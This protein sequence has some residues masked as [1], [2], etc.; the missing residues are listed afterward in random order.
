MVLS[1]R[2]FFTLTGASAATIILGSSLKNFYADASTNQ[3]QLTKKF[4]E[5]KPD[6]QGILDLPPGFQY[7]ILSPLGAI[8]DDGVAVPN[9]HDG[10]ATFPGTGNTT[11][12][13]RNHETI[14][15][16]PNPVIAPQD[17]KYD[18]LSGG[19]TTTLI[20]NRS[21]Q[22]VKHF[23][24]LAGTNRNCGGGTTPW[25]SWL[26]SEEDTSTLS[27]KHGYNFEVPAGE[28]VTNPV[29]LVAM[30]RFRHEAIAFEPVSGYIYQTEDQL[31]SC[32][33]RFIPSEYGNL[34]AGG[35]LETLKI[36]GMPKIDTSSNFPLREPKQVEWIT[37][38]QVDPDSDTLRYEAQ[39]KGAA[40]FRRGEGICL[41]D[42]QI[43]WTCTN[44]GKAQA[45]QIF[46]YDIKA[47]TIELFLESESKQILDYPD[48]I[49][50]SPFGDL[51]ACEDGAG[52]QYLVG[53]TPQGKCY[54][55]AHNA[56]NNSE[57]AGVC[58]SPDTQT[59]FVNIYNPGMTLAIWGPWQ[60]S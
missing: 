46:R 34:Q 17:H 3:T 2:N 24:S 60:S 6:P 33:Y 27:Q 22:L 16:Q 25:N 29:P 13:V 1:R 59:M 15:G 55:F 35:T 9:Y 20:V 4:G 43:Y 38:E 19:G 5:L 42:G 7:R 21:R 26:S 36:K 53:I 47:N 32:M 8:M 52:E 48:N 45:G 57:F 41:G 23:V 58:F 11:I 10:M 28:I 56:Y 37:I 12:L 51:I 18:Q 30:G 49:I 44:G 50:M 39:S 54:R 40:I 31:D 14:P